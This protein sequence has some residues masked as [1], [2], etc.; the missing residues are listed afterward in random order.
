[1][2]L[3]RRSP[4]PNI[5]RVGE[6]LERD[7]LLGTLRATLADG[8]RLVF[9]AGEAGAGKTTLVR[10]FGST[11]GVPVHHGSCENLA[12]PTPLGPFV[13]IAAFVGGGFADVVGSGSDPRAVGRALVAEMTTPGVVVLED[14]HWADQATL[15]AVRVLGRRIGGSRGLV[16]ATYRDDELDD[17][18]PLRHVL[19]ELATAP[20]VSRLSVP[21]LSRDAV[22][23][24][25]QDHDA[26]GDALYQ[27]TGG[28][29]FY[30]TE[31]LATGTES[32]PDTVRDAVLARVAPLGDGARHL[33]C[34][35]ALVPG[36]TEL[37]LLDAAAPDQLSHLDACLA[38]GVL[39]EAGDGVAFRH[40]LARLAVESSVTVARRRSLH[41][42]ILTALASPHAGPPDVSRLAH[43]AEAA[44]DVASVLEH[45]PVA[46]RQAAAAGAHREAAGQYARALRHA[47]G[48]SP[49]ERAELLRAYA[50]E[51]ELTGRFTEVVEARHEAAGLYRDLDDRLAEGHCLSRL[52]VPLLRAG[53]NTEAE[54]ASRAAIELLE[55]LPPTR[56]LGSAYAD[57]A[58]ARML[59]R[60]NSD[61]VMWGEKA[62]ALA[63]EL[64][65]R[66][67]IAFGLNM[68][69]TSH[70]MA[71]EIDRGV[72]YLRRSLALA[73]ADGME[74]RIA[75]AL[76]MLGSGLGEMYELES[77]ER[78][79]REQIAYAEAHDLWPQYSRAWLALV[80][81]YRG[82]W[83]DAV[84]LAHDVLVR[85]HDPISKIAALI[86]VGRVRAR[87]GDP[88][89]ADVLDEALELARPGGHLQRLGHVHAARAEARWLVG[90]TEQAAVEARAV[91]HLAVEK[92]HLWFAG[93]LA[94]WR[95]RAGDGEPW[96]DWLATPYRLELAGAA[97]EAGDAWR[98]RGCPYEAARA[99]SAA[100]DEKSL[101]EAL[102]DLE[103]LGA[104]PAAMRV[105][106][107]LGELGYSVPRGPRAATRANPGAL[108][109][110]E[111][112]VLELLSAGKRNAEIA[113]ELV[114]S[115]RTV[116]HHVS[117]IL[118]KLGVRN[119]GEA[120]SAAREHG[121]LDRV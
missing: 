115:R 98:D 27:L 86:A 82:R 71:G 72:G 6:L 64:G 76:G 81:V 104:G 87:R 83:D 108:T 22:R 37:W 93:E 10:A 36:R 114:V 17:A 113:A 65:D 49:R 16:V 59:S 11:S 58:Y 96:P 101:L 79:L 43:H 57:Q 18:H 34:V 112:D 69:G 90:D 44:G 116:D 9:I 38:A 67:T 46:A 1:M 117:A 42:A 30:V 48:L 23:R 20:D 52:T 89:A 68:V 119:R 95:H 118:R 103:R 54:A 39:R 62:V 47:A 24:L 102:G 61:G 55:T 8:G 111:L 60:D 94:Y 73:R 97:R 109:A 28:N 19:G 77:S 88:G 120:A 32:L 26:D 84:E 99:L 33:L 91:Y 75:S 5:R 40:E 56:E 35:V 100:D 53:R 3:I 50:D 29:P 85:A 51:A 12:T 78:Y 92:R 107:R 45:A 25:A 7:A 63:T 66:D 74:H 105:R 106:R 21:R 80:H 15:D 31:V 121:L 13:D 4:G 41:G 2:P 110:R 14:L 70:V